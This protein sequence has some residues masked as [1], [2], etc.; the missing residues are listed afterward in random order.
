MIMS[1]CKLDLKVYPKTVYTDLAGLPDPILLGLTIH[2]YNHS[3]QSLYMKIFISG[4]SPWSPNAVEL[5]SLGSGSNAYKNLDNFTSRTKP[6][7]ETTEELTLTLR[8]YNDSG[9]SELKYEFS[10]SLT[11]VF[12]KSDDGSWTTDINN[13]FDD[14]TV[15]GW[16][17]IAELRGVASLGVATDYVLSPPYSLCLHSHCEFEYECVE[18]EVRHRIEKAFTTPN[19]SKVYAVMNIRVSSGTGPVGSTKYVE[20]RTASAT[21]IH[22]GKLYVNDIVDYIPVGKWMRIVIPLPSNASVTIQIAVDRRGSTFGYGL[23]GA[24]LWLDDFKIISK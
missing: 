3:D 9:Y 22:L 23:Y 7:Q 19:K 15:Q 13:N 11:V 18:Q 17:A 5:G 6:S 21:L 24:Y 4:P 20:V 16:S 2:Y 1:C 8:G 10:R 12:I 14:G